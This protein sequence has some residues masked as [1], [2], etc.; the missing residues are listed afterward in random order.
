MSEPASKLEW[1]ALVSLGDYPV[2]RKERYDESQKRAHNAIAKA[3]MLERVQRP[4]RAAQTEARGEHPSEIAAT[5]EAKTRTLLKFALDY[6]SE[7]DEVKRHKAA[8]QLLKASEEYHRSFTDNEKA[9]N[10]RHNHPQGSTYE[11]RIDG[12]DYTFT[13]AL[14]WSDGV[15]FLNGASDQAVMDLL[16]WALNPSSGPVSPKNPVWFPHARGDGRIY[17]RLQESVQRYPALPDALEAIRVALV[18]AVQERKAA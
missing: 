5:L 4:E 17:W 7:G 2:K 12:R 11:V 3:L 9:R 13:L 10:E 16:N 15:R 18:P 14:H 1:A 8:A 6:A